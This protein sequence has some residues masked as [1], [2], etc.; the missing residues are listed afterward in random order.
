MLILSQFLKDFE[1]SK[2][3]NLRKIAGRAYVVDPGVE[4]EPRRFFD[5]F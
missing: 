5:A 2:H 1:G 4:H 3:A